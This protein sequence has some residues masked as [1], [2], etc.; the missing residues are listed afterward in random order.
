MNKKLLLFIAGTGFAAT[1]SAQCVTP[2]APTATAA[3][4]AAI[5]SDTGGTTLLSATVTPGNFIAWYDA[6]VGGNFLGLTTST[7]SLPVTAPGTTIYYAEELS[8]GGTATQTFS[9]TGAVQFWV[10]PFGTDSVTLEAWGAQ[11]NANSLGITGGLGGYATG[12]LAVTAG[13]TLWIKVGGG[14]QTTPTPGYNGGGAGGTSPC[15][16]AAAG[17]GGGASDIR[18]MGISL[19]SRVLVGAGGGG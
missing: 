14:G 11:G 9:Y 3:N 10:V 6:P 12:K 4:P 17:G 1:V 13:D 7:G 15:A 5:C 2:P 18:Y 8:T 19:A 16:T